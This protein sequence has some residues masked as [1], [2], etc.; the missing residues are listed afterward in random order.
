MG[1]LET[2]ATNCHYSLRNSPDERSSHL[3]C[4]VSLKA[5]KTFLNAEM[6][7]VALRVK[8]YQL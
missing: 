6:Y 8:Y 4:G 3:L 1:C 2:P 5:C 7:D